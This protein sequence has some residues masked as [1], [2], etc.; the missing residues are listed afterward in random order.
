[1]ELVKNAVSDIEADILLE[2]IYD[3]QWDDKFKSRRTQDYGYFYDYKRR[4]LSSVSD[5]EKQKIDKW[6]VPDIVIEKMGYPEQ[7]IVNEYLHGQSISPH[8]DSDVFGP[9]ICIL[10][11][12]DSEKMTLK[13]GKDTKSVTLE[14]NSLLVLSDDYRSKY[15]HSIT[16]HGNDKRVSITYRSVRK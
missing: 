3:L 11:L 5:Q 13:Y 12:C 6:L 16:Y 8:V 4:K 15:A 1:M 9:I 7:V 10:S 14:K 2:K